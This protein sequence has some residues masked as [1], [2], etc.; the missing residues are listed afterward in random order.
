MKMSK[1]VIDNF[2]VRDDWANEAFKILAAHYDEI[3]RWALNR[4][5]YR[6]EVDGCV[7]ALFF[8]P[9]NA[10]PTE[11]QRCV[12]I[13]PYWEANPGCMVQVSCEDGDEVVDFT[14][15]VPLKWDDATNK[16]ASFVARYKA[17]A[18]VYLENL[19]VYDYEYV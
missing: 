12:H 4:Y 15:C 6:F 10:S 5:G 11:D 2:E 1:K 13:T 9:N 14:T 3:D 19:E 7:G 16:P 8:S 18:R 17:I